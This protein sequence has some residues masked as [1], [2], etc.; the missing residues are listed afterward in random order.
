MLTEDISGTVGVFMPLAASTA[1]KLGANKGRWKIGILETTKCFINASI[2]FLIRDGSGNQ[3]KISIDNWLF[4]RDGGF[5]PN[6]Q[7]CSSI[8]N[9]ALTEMSNVLPDNVVAYLLDADITNTAVQSMYPSNRGQYKISKFAF[10]WPT[11]IPTAA[12]AG[13]YSDIGATTLA[14]L[15]NNT[16]LSGLT[17]KTGAILEPA[18][19]A[20][21]ATKLRVAGAR[22]FFKCLAGEA[23]PAAVIGASSYLTG[24]SGGA[25]NTNLGFVNFGAAHGFT[26]GDTVVIT[27]SVTAAL[28]GTFKLV[29]VPTTTQITVY[30]DSVAAVGTAAA[31]TADAAI[32]V[33]LKPTVN[34]IAF[35]DDYGF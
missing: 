13:V 8:N 10:L 11:K 25:G 21:E 7:L 32:S 4:Q 5:Y 9:S 27:A 23:A 18:L 33:Q 16:A 24:R 3:T 30:V 20:A 6:Q 31:P 12:T 26:V 22:V 17:S 28:N 29:D 34:V 14:T 35:G 19:A 2:A 15:V 1:T